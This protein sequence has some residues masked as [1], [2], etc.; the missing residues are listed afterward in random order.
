VLI[1]IYYILVF[2][3]PYLL[4][5]YKKGINTFLLIAI[6]VMGELFL[7]MFFEMLIGYFDMH[8]Y[9]HMIAKRG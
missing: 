7:R 1:I 3:T 6:I 8:D 2:I 5:K 4:F 9:L